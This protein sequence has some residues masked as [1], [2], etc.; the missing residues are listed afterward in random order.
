MKCMQ[1]LFHSF[2]LNCLLSDETVV[3]FHKASIKKYPFEEI[4]CNNGE[5]SNSVNYAFVSKMHEALRFEV[6]K[7]H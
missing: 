5:Y 6:K 4:H 1:N 2:F 3:T 7:V